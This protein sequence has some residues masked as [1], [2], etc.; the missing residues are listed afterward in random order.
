MPP[1]YHQLLEE[2]MLVLGEGPRDSGSRGW[3]SWPLGNI[4][5]STCACHN[6]MALELEE[7]DNSDPNPG[8]NSDMQYCI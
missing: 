6:E 2:L 5:Y 8:V 7:E 1:L 4:G 3:D